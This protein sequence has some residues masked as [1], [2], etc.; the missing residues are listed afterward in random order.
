ML[1]IKQE[2]GIH[3]PTVKTSYDGP[4]ESTDDCLAVDDLGISDSSDNDG[5]IENTEHDD[6]TPT[7]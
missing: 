7:K 4:E 6:V 5:V 3:S 2:R 1:F